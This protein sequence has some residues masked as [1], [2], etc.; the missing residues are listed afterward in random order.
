M[1]RGSATLACFVL[2][3]IV[4]VA[5]CIVS[6]TTPF[7]NTEE[8][9]QFNPGARADRAEPIDADEVLTDD[10]SKGPTSPRSESSSR[11]VEREEPADPAESLEPGRS[12]SGYFSARRRRS[13]SNDTKVSTSWAPVLNDEA[14][15]CTGPKEPVN[16]QT[17][18]VGPAIDDFAFTGGERRCGGGSPAT[19]VNYVSYIYGKCV[20][21]RGEGGCQ[22]PLEI[23]TWPACQRYFAKYSFRGEP[24][25]HN[26]L[27]PVDGAQ[28]LEIN[29]TLDQRIEVSSGE[30]TIVIF[31]PD[32]SLAIEAAEMLRSE[33]RQSPIATVAR[34]LRDNDSSRLAPPAEGSIEGGLSCR[35]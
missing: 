1:S 4:V 27:T 2:V 22:P 20:P 10:S 32:R 6:G 12:G 8:G 21:P 16:F 9:V 11:Q 28:V 29:F 19:R 31:S 34:E 17:F 5:Y 26:W 3:G 14:L 7:P 25:P 13:K 24:L 33:E 23:Q 15:P 35:T 18:S 30:S